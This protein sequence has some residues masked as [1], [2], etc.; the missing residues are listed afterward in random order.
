FEANNG[1]DEY[2]DIVDK[3]LRTIG[4]KLN[5]TSRT[6]LSSTN[7]LTRILVAAPDIVKNFY[8]L[9]SK[10]QSRE[11]RSFMRE[12]TSF[13]QMKKNKHDD[14]PDSLSMLNDMKSQGQ[15]VQVFKRPF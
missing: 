5:I 12:L 10:H 1:G 2:A 4:V 11:Y 15:S 9:D 7:K 13:S 14:A 6:T 3:D 8:F